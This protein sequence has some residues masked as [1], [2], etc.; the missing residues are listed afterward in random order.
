MSTDADSRSITISVLLR[1]IKWVPWT[2]SFLT[3]M[4]T[5][6]SFNYSTLRLGNKLVVTEQLCFHTLHTVHS[7][8]TT[9]QIVTSV[10][11]SLISDYLFMVYLAKNLDTHCMFPDCNLQI[12][13]GYTEIFLGVWRGECIMAEVCT[14]ILL[15]TVNLHTQWC[16]LCCT[17]PLVWK[18]E[19]FCNLL[20]N[21][22][23]KI[24]RKSKW[25]Y[26]KH[27]YSLYY[28]CCPL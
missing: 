6:F 25:H 22:L 28:M 10:L 27:F 23:L 15:R 9:C 7:I 12:P 26:F 19:I 24:N 3:R 13:F 14:T 1:N 11:V 18:N 20:E 17:I 5:I 16:G 2:F 21:Y 4:K 8:S